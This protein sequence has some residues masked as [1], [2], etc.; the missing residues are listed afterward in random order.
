[1][2]LV[3][4]TAARWLFVV[5]SLIRGER[6]TGGVLVGDVLVLTAPLGGHAHL[7]PLEEEELV[8]EFLP[9]PTIVVVTVQGGLIWYKP[10][11]KHHERSVHIHHRSN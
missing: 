9:L 6:R 11:I 10:T 3:D 7:P 2:L 1:M 5:V 4:A 8:E